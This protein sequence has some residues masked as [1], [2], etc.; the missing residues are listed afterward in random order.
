[1][2]LSIIE[3][4]TWCCDAECRKSAHNAECHYAACCHDQKIKIV[5]DFML[6]FANVIIVVSLTKSKKK[7]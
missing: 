3:F 4:C 6:L 7:V 2:T 5:N 1:M